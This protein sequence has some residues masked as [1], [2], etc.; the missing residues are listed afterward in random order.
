[1]QPLY[2]YAPEVLLPTLLL[3]LNLSHDGVAIPTAPPPLSLASSLSSPAF[4]TTSSFSSSVLVVVA[5]VCY[6]LEYFGT[7]F[8]YLPRK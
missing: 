4:T 7:Y 2:G 1:M 8:G 6:V 5:G 3:Y